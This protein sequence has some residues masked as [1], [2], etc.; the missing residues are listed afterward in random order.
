[1]DRIL[2]CLGG[3]PADFA[4]AIVDLTIVRNQSL[5]RIHHMSATEPIANDVI[6]EMAKYFTSWR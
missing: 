6:A 3:P 4:T 1:M 5:F 2:R